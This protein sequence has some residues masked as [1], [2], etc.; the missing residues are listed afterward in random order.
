M[1]NPK[2]GHVS[3]CLMSWELWLQSEHLLQKYYMLLTEVCGMF[4]NEELEGSKFHSRRNMF[5]NELIICVTVSVPLIV[6][7]H[8]R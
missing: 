7:L 3:S 1:V 4:F 8:E 5:S 6:D 2:P